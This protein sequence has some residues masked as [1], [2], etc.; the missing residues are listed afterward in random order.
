MNLTKPTDLELGRAPQ[1]KTRPL[2]TSNTWATMLEQELG[3]LV[4]GKKT[5]HSATDSW[6]LVGSGIT[7]MSERLAMRL[8]KRA[9]EGLGTTG[10]STLCH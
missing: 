5:F 1:S 2:Q 6:D 9:G 10:Q 3:F 4:F 8:S 7:T